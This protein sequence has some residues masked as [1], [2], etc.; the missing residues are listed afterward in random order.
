MN[1]KAESN[2]SKEASSKQWESELPGNNKDDDKKPANADDYNPRENSVEDHSKSIAE[3]RSEFGIEAS[4][5]KSH[6]HSAIPT[7]SPNKH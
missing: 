5:T 4:K 3:M 1:S 2:P 6:E 7:P